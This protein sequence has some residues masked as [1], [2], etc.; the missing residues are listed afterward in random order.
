MPKSR[1]HNLTVAGIL[2]IVP[3]S[4][5]FPVLAFFTICPPQYGRYLGMVFFL[6]FAASEAYG[7]IAAIRSVKRKLD[8]IGG[9]AILCIA[10]G[11][12]TFGFIVWL[13]IPRLHQ[14]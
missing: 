5:V 10:G 6:G 3:A 7:I 8:L 13:F 9:V 14:G 2:V 11:L 12:L 1:Q 4:L